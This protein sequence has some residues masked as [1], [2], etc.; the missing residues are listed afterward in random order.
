M[1][2]HPTISE[3][4]A[5]AYLRALY[6]YGV[7]HVFAN[8]GTDFAPIVEGLLG[9]N[10][11]GMK[12]PHFVTIPHENVAMAMAVG[13]YKVARIPASVM[14]HTTVG[15]ANAICGVMNADRGN[16]PVLLAAGRSPATETGHLGSRNIGIHW[17]QENFDQGGMLR[18]YVRWDYELRSGQPVNTVVGRALDI[19]MTDPMGPVYLT[20]PREVLADQAVAPG[21]DPRQR[22]MGTLSAAPAAEAIEQA[23][24]ILAGAERVLIIGGSA[25]PKG[26]HALARLAETH[27][28]ACAPGMGSYMPSSHG[29]NL[30]G[31]TE[32]LLAWADA[33]VVLDTA[34]PWVPRFTGPEASAKLI[35]IANDPH[36]GRYPYR[37][38][39]MDLAISGSVDLA[40]PLLDGALKSKL[41][42]KGA[43]IDKRRAEIAEMRQALLDRRASVLDRG[44]TASPIS[45]AWTAK[46]INDVKDDDAIFFNE[47]GVPPGFMDFDQPGCSM[48]GGGSAGGLGSSLGGALGAKIA[49]PDRQ[50]IG[51]VGDGSY[52]FNVPAAC[53]FLQRSENLPT[54]TVI[55]NNAQYFAVRNATVSMYPDGRAAKANSLPVVDLTPSPD[56]SKIID[57]CDGYGQKVDDPAKLP[58]ALECGLEAVAKGDPAVINVVTAAG[59]RS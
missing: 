25:A 18:E 43:V 16:V 10:E 46:C 41:K 42:T 14:V 23:A 17:S 3:T 20:L 29:M 30:G 6:E 56:Y 48:A 4:V 34:V 12:V 22:P 36:F 51:A 21:S 5:E 57:F 47:L 49:A 9:A 35:H 52:M 37:G 15:T 55:S 45:A 58:A 53:H 50:V 26:F 1:D 2:S 24:D 13:Y 39:Q 54:L 11:T 8:G 7:R 33:V 44:R 27:A 32:K 28:I 59:G 40:L 38:Y 31:V 19:A